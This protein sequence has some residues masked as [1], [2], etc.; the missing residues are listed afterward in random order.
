MKSTYNKLWLSL[1]IAA[2]LVIGTF[3]LCFHNQYIS[4]DISDWASFGAYVGGCFSLVSVILVCLT[5][6]EQSKMS[7]KTQFE[8]VFFDM[9][10]TLRELKTD[11]IS[12]TFSDIQEKVI[13]HF[14]SPFTPN[15]INPTES[16]EAIAYYFQLHNNSDV[17][18]HYFRYLYHIVMYVCSDKSLNDK[19]KEK[20]VSLIQA[21]MSNDELLTTLFNVINYGNTSYIEVLDKY[22]LFENLRS[23]NELL[24]FIIIILFP[25]TTFKHLINPNSECDVIY[26]FELDSLLHEKEL[27]FDTIDRLKKAK[28]ER[29]Q[30]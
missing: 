28:I 16:K 11:D 5:F 25:R 4:N 2:I 8:S 22:H 20:Y 3:L 30:S 10:H 14:N 24:D 23:I 6:I 15:D 29:Q 18:H 7:Y 27:Y 9:L 17:I 1:V 13:V 19:E 21:Q 12:R 26:D